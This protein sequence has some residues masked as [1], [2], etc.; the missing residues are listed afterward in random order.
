MIPQEAIDLILESEGLDQPSRWPGGGSG[1]TLGH[2]YDL[3]FYSAEEFERD[4]SPH[5]SPEQIARL[6]TALGKTG[7]N[8]RAIAPRFRDIRISETAAREVFARATLPKFEAQTRRAFLGVELL[9]ALVLGVLTS[10]VFNRGPGMTGERR[11]EMFAIRAAIE[12]WSQRAPSTREAALRPLLLIIAAQIR[13]MK[14]LW[15]GQGL[16]GLLRRRDAEARL[17]ESAIPA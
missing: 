15:I 13:A 7:A 14:R 4:W 2:G 6:K 8:A 16:D 3:G 1:I 12:G 17:I 9:P 11:R 10:L 5:L